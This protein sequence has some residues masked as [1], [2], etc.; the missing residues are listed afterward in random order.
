M[1]LA[2]S[3]GHFIALLEQFNFSHVL[4]YR[5]EQ[6]AETTNVC[7]NLWKVF[8]D[9]CNHLASQVF[10]GISRQTHPNSI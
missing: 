8:I 10:F 5:Q 9:R 4:Q 1:S 3:D 6:S 7:L 2:A